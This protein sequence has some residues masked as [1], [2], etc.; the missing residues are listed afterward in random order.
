[1][2]KYAESTQVSV[3]KS[4]GEI[5]RTLQRYGADAFGYLYRDGLS[6]IEFS[7]NGRHVRFRLPLPKRDSEEF[8]KTPTGKKRSANSA[9][10]AW[11]QA[12]RQRWRA[13]ALCIKAKL[14]AVECGITLFEEEFLAH[15]VDPCT[16]RTVGEV[17]L[18]QVERSYIEGDPSPLM[19]EWKG[20]SD[21]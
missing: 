4:R 12:C 9:V 17:V 8:T 21:G 15:I 14:E 3:E 5:E 10:A 18:P 1:M 2:S 6:I 19:M 16:N 11:E 20:E 7:A 13:L